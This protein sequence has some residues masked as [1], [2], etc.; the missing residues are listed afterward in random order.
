ME[1]PSGFAFDPTASNP[2]AGTPPSASYSAHGILPNGMLS[3]AVGQ[4]QAMLGIPG[5]LPAASMMHM[6]PSPLHESSMNHNLRM[7]H[8]LLQQHHAAA[9]AAA[10]FKPPHV[11][12]T[13]RDGKGVDDEYDPDKENDGVQVAIVT[14]MKRRTWER[15]RVR[16]ARQPMPN[17]A[18]TATKKARLGKGKFPILQSIDDSILLC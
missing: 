6:G 1:G 10:A 9:A 8:A 14:L 4:Q 3:G 11:A 13:A 17:R 15:R 2:F 16:S 18:R 5:T 7:Q 12:P